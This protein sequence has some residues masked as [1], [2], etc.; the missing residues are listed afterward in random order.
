M[1]YQLLIPSII[2]SLSVL[3]ATLIAF[4]YRRR[5]SC[6][7]ANIS[8]EG[9]ITVEVI[10][11]ESGVTIPSDDNTISTARTMAPSIISSSIK[12]LTGNNGSSQRKIDL[13][14]VISPSEQ[15]NNSIDPNVYKIDII[16]DLIGQNVKIIDRGCINKEPIIQ[17]IMHNGKSNPLPELTETQRNQDQNLDI[18]N[19]Y[20]H[21]GP[22]SPGMIRTSASGR[23][24]SAYKQMQQQQLNQNTKFARNI[25]HDSGIS[26]SNTN[27]SQDDLSSTGSV[28]N[29]FGF[30]TGR[31]N[32][33][34]SNSSQ[35]ALIQSI[36]PNGSINIRSVRGYQRP[37]YN[38]SSHN[39]SNSGA[40]GQN[41][42]SKIRSTHN[43]MINTNGIHKVHH[44][45]SHNRQPHSQTVITN[46]GVHRVNSISHSTDETSSNLSEGCV[47]G[48]SN[49]NNSVK[50]LPE[51]IPN[52][53][54]LNIRVENNRASLKLSSF[55]LPPLGTPSQSQSAMKR[56]VSTESDGSAM[57]SLGVLR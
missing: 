9:V 15:Q 42:N 22:G 12:H 56:I 8:H 45:T 43:H 30:R 33:H 6:K 36:S 48:V 27:G 37:N 40:P 53:D 51:F 39:I 25:S 4:V 3:L 47:S 55:A 50:S 13:S 31:T 20:H 41:N 21:S 18:Y 2:I 44:M 11:N 54:S 10:A 24:S 34:H 5:R 38:T 14:G 26:Q 57:S 46:S 23:R 49:S 52:Y 32:S 35:R 29:Y 16:D 28:R 17:K 1:V 7:T 19:Q